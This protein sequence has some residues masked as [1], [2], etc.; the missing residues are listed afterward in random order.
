MDDNSQLTNDQIPADADPRAKDILDK[1]KKRADETVT[2]RQSTEQE[3]SEIDAEATDASTKAKKMIGELEQKSRE[4][5]KKLDGLLLD[6]V[7]DE[8]EDPAKA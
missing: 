6:W 3:L 8:A 2:L 5:D 7:K 1:A 4:T